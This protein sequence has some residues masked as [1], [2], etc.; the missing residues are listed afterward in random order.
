MINS[1]VVRE[2]PY[3]EGFFMVI[4]C[5]RYNSSS[6][7]ENQLGKARMQRMF[8]SFPAG[9]PGLALLLLRSTAGLVLISGAAYSS[10][11]ADEATL[12]V[13]IL[14]IAALASGLLLLLGF[15]TPI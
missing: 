1:N 6:A 11:K 8:S 4:A 5:L 13:L 15:F 14:A 9:W 7:P 3:L 10:S 12:L 2:K